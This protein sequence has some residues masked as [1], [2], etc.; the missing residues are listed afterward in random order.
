MS[1][2]VAAALLIVA[3]RSGGWVGWG[4]MG[5]AAAVERQRDSRRQKMP[6]KVK[7]SSRD[8]ETHVELEGCIHMCLYS[9]MFL[10]V[11]PDKE[12]CALQHPELRAPPPHSVC[13]QT[14]TPN[15]HTHTKKDRNVIFME[16]VL[17]LL[18]ERCFEEMLLVVH[19]HCGE[20][21]WC[22]SSLTELRDGVGCDLTLSDK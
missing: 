20:I 21:A 17:D 10:S 18:M 12:V 11:S 14:T 19:A 8:S 15:T 22:L 13:L 9:R 1:E 7:R 4:G 6:A 16:T 3:R 5:E 2:L